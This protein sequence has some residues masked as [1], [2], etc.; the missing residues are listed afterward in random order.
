LPE[1]RQPV[2]P[3]DQHVDLLRGGRRLRRDLELFD[4]PRH[5]LPSLLRALGSDLRQEI[6]NLL[7]RG[8]VFRDLP[9]IFSRLFPVGTHLAER[10]HQG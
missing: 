5:L 3:I 7:P 4:D 8:R 1:F 6:Q 2:E 9:Q 10:V